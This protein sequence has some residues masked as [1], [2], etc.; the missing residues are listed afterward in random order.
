MEESKTIYYSSKFPWARE[1]IFSKL[2]AKF[3]MRPQKA[4]PAPDWTVGWS[5]NKECF[6]S[7]QR[8]HWHCSLH[9]V[10]FKKYQKLSSRLG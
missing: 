1:R 2:V 9:A 5:M 8:P 3:D 4:F 10:F 7:P 6:C